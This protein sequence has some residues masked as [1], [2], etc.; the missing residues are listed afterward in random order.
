[1]AAVLAVC[2]VRCGPCRLL[3][4]GG[5]Y[6]VGVSISSSSPL[7]HTLELLTHPTS[8]VPHPDLYKIFFHFKACVHEQS[9]FYVPP[10]LALFTPLQY[11][12]TTIAQCTTLI[13]TPLLY[14]IHH[15]ISVLAISCKGQPTALTLQLHGTFEVSKRINLYTI[16]SSPIL[17]GIWHMKGELGGGHILRKSRSIVLQ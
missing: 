9:Y 4:F 2:C 10:P 5:G 15:I 1:M 14:A 3:C 8:P 11:L 6:P 16:L 7:T 12:C 17:Y 13:P